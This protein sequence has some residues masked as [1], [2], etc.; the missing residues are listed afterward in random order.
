MVRH[1]RRY[2]PDVQL[3][4][5]AGLINDEFNVDKDEFEWPVDPNSLEVEMEAATTDPKGK[6]RSK[7]W[8]Y[9]ERQVQLVHDQQV[10][11]WPT[12]V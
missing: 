6:I 1:L 11:D 10:F 4:T 12:Q 5:F 7:V 2:H 8:N 3:E 9:F